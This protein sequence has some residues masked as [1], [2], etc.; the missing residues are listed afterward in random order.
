MLGPFLP[1]QL[2][3]LPARRWVTDIHFAVL[4][5]SD[6]LRRAQRTP[7]SA[8]PVGFASMSAGRDVEGLVFAPRRRDFEGTA[9]GPHGG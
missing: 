9:G 3:S 1:D 5:C 7:P 8:W 4:D 2:A 6:D